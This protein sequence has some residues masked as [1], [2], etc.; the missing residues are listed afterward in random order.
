MA[1]PLSLD[2]EAWLGDLK[3]GKQA[4]VVRTKLR[5]FEGTLGIAEPVDIIEFL[6][7]EQIYADLV[8]APTKKL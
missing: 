4:E 8:P 1:E 2:L 6:M 7:P 5:A 3:L